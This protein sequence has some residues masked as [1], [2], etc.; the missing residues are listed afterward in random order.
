[1]KK[2]LL[3]SKFQGLPIHRLYNE[4]VK[5]PPND[6]KIIKT[7]EYKEH[8]LTKSI[9]K[10]HNNFY[11]EFMYHTGGLPYTITQMLKTKSDYSDVDLVYAVQHIMNTK[12][13]WITDLEFSDALA[14]YCSL[15][16]CKNIITKQ[17]MAK[18]C[19]AILPWSNWAK[20]TLLCSIDCKKFEEKIQVVRFTVPPKKI[21]VKK[22]KSKI[23]ILFLGSGNIANM[24]SF[25]YKGMHETVLAFQ[26]LEKKFDNIELIIRSSVPKE[27]KHMIKENKNIQIIENPITEEQL[28]E[29]FLTT[30]IF[31]HPGCE[32]L[33]FSDLE[34]MSYGIP[35]IRPA[36]F[37]IPEAIKNMENG[38]LLDVPLKENLYGKCGIPKEH[39]FSYIKTIRKIRPQMAEGL[40]NA[41][42]ILIE[43]ESLRKR[44][45]QN[46]KKTIDEG[47]FSMKRRNEKLKKIF[48]YAT[49]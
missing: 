15:T 4:L 12:K 19:K 32:T 10:H 20:K 25:E 24:L 46:A 16:F 6:Y 38:L 41:I 30:D 48:D 22:N 23:R 1:M 27:I 31:P 47:E 3:K 8:P 9:S 42:Q 35:V 11:K 33:N 2:I 43:N 40:A 39:S 5:N 45:S 44:L 28:K 17:L 37:N 7:K 18:S 14:G 34:A 21:N 29:L 49:S 36:L 26:K 13:P